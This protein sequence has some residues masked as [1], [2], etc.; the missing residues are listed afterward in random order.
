[1]AINQQVIEAQLAAL[2]PILHQAKYMERMLKIALAFIEDHKLGPFPLE[3]T[4]DQKD[5]IESEYQSRKTILK[6]LADGF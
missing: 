6:D 1:M 4:S 3:L 2:T 5:E